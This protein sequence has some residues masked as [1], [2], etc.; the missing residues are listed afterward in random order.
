[1]TENKPYVNAALCIHS[2][3]WSSLLFFSA[4]ECEMLAGAQ[5]TSPD[6]WQ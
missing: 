1:M 4:V 5:V 6:D 2:L 3:A